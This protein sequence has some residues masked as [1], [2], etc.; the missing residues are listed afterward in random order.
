ML[1]DFANKG[2][3]TIII[4]GVITLGAILSAMRQLADLDFQLVVLEDCCADYD[5]EV[6]KILIEKVFPK[7]AKVIKSKEL[8]ALL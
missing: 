2:I 3:E 7:Q 6:H 1:D 4:G 8:G 5:A